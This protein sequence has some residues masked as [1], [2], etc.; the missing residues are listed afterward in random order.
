[1][2]TRAASRRLARH[3]PRGLPPA[4]AD[5]MYDDFDRAT[6]RAVLALYR[7]VGDLDGE[8]ERVIAALR[9]RDLPALVLWGA[10]DRYLPAAY[11]ERQRAA[12]P[13]AVVE[14]LEGSGHWPFVDAADTVADRLTRF[15]H[16]VA[17]S[18]AGACASAP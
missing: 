11:A 3:E 4:I 1:V 12:F 6:R 8:A 15:L 17:T 5:R 13:S 7:S 2:T 9:P 18:R 10:R 14:V 16:R